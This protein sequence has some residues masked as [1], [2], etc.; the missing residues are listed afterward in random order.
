MKTKVL[1]V[2]A[3]ILT[4][5]LLMVPKIHAQPNPDIDGDG[6]VN[7]S[8]VILAASQYRLIASDP[9]Y[10]AAIVEKADFTGDGMVNLIDMVTLIQYYSS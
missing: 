8:D 4:I 2:L 5:A 7:I 1:P 9:G 6:H 10:D 3:L